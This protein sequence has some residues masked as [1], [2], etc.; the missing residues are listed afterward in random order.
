MTQLNKM[1]AYDFTPANIRKIYADLSKNLSS[2]IE[3]AILKQFD[4]LYYQDSLEKVNNIHY[5]NGWKTN[6][7]F[8]INKK[9]IIR[10]TY[11]DDGWSFPYKGSDILEEFEKIF[12]YLDDEKRDG[13]PIYPILSK[14]FNRWNYAGER[15]H[16]KYFDVEFKKKGTL[17]LWFNDLELLKKFNIFGANKKGWLPNGYG[18]KSYS[19]M[20]EEE[21][22]VV[23]SFEGKKEYE[24]TMRNS[25]Y[26]LGNTTQNFLGIGKNT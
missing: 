9:V 8:K 25:S 26:Y 16:F 19:E 7:A 10:H 21:K 15:L 18:K 1:R 13:E 11:N 23:N 14:A 4:E 5:F 20:N 22:E 6:S 2:N 12:T 17:H 24:D 3:Q